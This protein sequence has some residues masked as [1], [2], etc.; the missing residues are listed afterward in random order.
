MNSAEIKNPRDEGRVRATVKSVLD[1]DED[2]LRHL[3]SK[4]QR[5]RHRS[6]SAEQPASSHITGCLAC[7]T[8][9]VSSK[10]NPNIFFLIPAQCFTHGHYEAPSFPNLT[11]DKRNA[12]D[13]KSPENPA[14]RLRGFTRPIGPRNPA[15]EESITP[16]PASEP[17]NPTP[18]DL[19][20]TNQC[21]K[22][23][24]RSSD[25]ITTKG[26]T[27]TN[28]EAV[29]AAYDLSLRESCVMANLVGRPCTEVHKYMRFMRPGPYA[30]AVEDKLVKGGAKFDECKAHLHDTAPQPMPCYHPGLSCPKAGQKCSC[31]RAKMYC[32]DGCPCPS[33]CNRRYPGCECAGGCVRAGVPD[34]ITALRKCLHKRGDDKNCIGCKLKSLEVV[35]YNAACRCQK[36][37]REC[38]PGVCKCDVEECLSPKGSLSK[39]KCQNCGIQE[40]KSRDMVLT[41]SS[42]AGYGVVLNEAVK[43]GDYLGEYV[44]E[45]ITKE[46]EEERHALLD[47]RRDCNYLFTLNADLTIDSG[48]CGNVTR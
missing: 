33:D 37:N 1:I 5:E 13:R 9:A 44:G 8:D 36:L 20:C 3:L 30:T 46:R 12:V 28:R 21:Y 10:L 29:Q 32:N 27:T 22:E 47:R 42:L 11:A 23:G 39:A 48:Y 26:W 34:P 14:D 40:G 16:A 31:T 15:D 4:Q 45:I 17:Q 25:K 7:A 35:N 38:T 24:W 43:Y 2:G 19:S 6:A 18:E 41:T